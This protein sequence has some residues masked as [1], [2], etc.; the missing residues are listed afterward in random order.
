MRTWIF[1]LLFGWLLTSSATPVKP[2]DV[3]TNWYD[4]FIFK[5]PSFTFEFIRTLGYTY[6]KGVDVGEAVSTAKKITDGD[7]NSWYKEWLYTAERVEKIGEQ[8]KQNGHDVSAMEAFF[9][10]SNYYRNAGFYMDS[11]AN[12]AKSISSYSK[13]KQNF[14]KAIS[15]LPYVKEVRIPYENTTLPGYLIG[16]D[17]VDAPI[18]IVNT[19]FDGTAEELYFEVGVALHARGYNCLLVEGPGQGSVLRE[20][21]LPFRPDWEMVMH[22]IVDFVE[23][24]PNVNKNKIA[25]MG[26]SMGG[27]LAPRAA[28]FEP[29][30]KALIANSGVYDFGATAYSSLPADA[31]ALIDKDPSAFNVIIEKEMQK[32]AEARWFFENGMWAFHVKS[33]AEFMKK[34]KLYTLENIAQNIKAPTL[35]IKSEADAFMQNQ[36]ELLYQ[37]LKSPK[38]LLIFT[39]EEA[40]QS[41][42]QMGATAISNELIFDWLDDTFNVSEPRVSKRRTSEWVQYPL[43]NGQWHLLKELYPFT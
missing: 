30:I 6:E 36:P 42:C 26:I 8:A 24:L 43:P 9:R 29:R 25:L 33:P 15:F 19:G 11:P 37:H 18:V 28:A 23:T 21:H 22:P 41:H 27:Y 14:L 32:S 38:T 1:L 40:A 13:S 31:I 10:T 35:V 12:Q 39:R 16:V 2:E 3:K 7:F 17:K 20:Q 5:D 4:N 34:V